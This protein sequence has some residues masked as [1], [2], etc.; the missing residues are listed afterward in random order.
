MKLV[1]IPSIYVFHGNPIIRVI[2]TCKS[3]IC[4]QIFTEIFFSLKR[5]YPPLSMLDLQKFIDVNRIDVTRP[6][7][8][9]AIINT[10]LYKLAPDQHQFGVQLTDEGADIFSAKINLEV[11]W[12]SELIIAA[13]EK[14]GG[15]ITTAYYDIHSL[16]AMM[17]SKKFF[18]RGKGL[19]IS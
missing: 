10:G 14:A 5:Q 11:Q 3:N 17:N 13:V 2:S 12:A 1:T 7:D 9:V 16:Q 15:V 6:V 8:L 4:P 18:E 19:I